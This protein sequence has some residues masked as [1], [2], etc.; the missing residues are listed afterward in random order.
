MN[1]TWT[2][3]GLTAMLTVAL[4]AC[5]RRR[6]TRRPAEAGRPAPGAGAA[7]Q[8]HDPQLPGGPEGH[9]RVARGGRPPAERP[10]RAEERPPAGG[11]RPGRSRVGGRGRAWRRLSGGA[12]GDRLAQRAGRTAPEDVGRPAGARPAESRT[13]NYGP[14]GDAAASGT[15]SIV[16]LNTYPADVTIVVDGEGYTLAP[17]ERRVLAGRPAGAFTYEVVGVQPPVQR[18]LASGGAFPIHVHP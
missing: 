11:R 4:A 6:P 18:T 13:S 14:P 12:K 3:L 9:R 17:G 5:P 2:T 1:R 15:G 10:G 7:P 8:R 16:L